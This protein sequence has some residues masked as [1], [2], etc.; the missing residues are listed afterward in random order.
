[1]SKKGFGILGAGMIAPL[2]ADALKK[3]DK[4][5]LVAICDLDESRSK[6]LAEK[7]A[8]DAK[9]Y[10]SLEDML[11]DKDVEVVNVVTPNHL[12]T[13]AVLKI[14][15]SK[16]HV[17]C[18]KPPAMSLADTDKMI[19]ACDDAGVLF[20]IYVQCRTRKP[21]QLMKQAIDEGRF[22]KIY[23]ADATMKWFRSG[24]YYKM[25]A[26]RSN[27]K[28]GAGVTIQHAFHY[29]DLIQYLMG[30]ASKVDAKMCNLGHPEV[31]LEDTLDARIEFKNGAI[32]AVQASTALWPGNDPRIEVYGENGTAIMD[33]AHFSKWEFKDAK[34]E[35][36]EVRN[37][38]NSDQKTAGSDPTALDSIDHQIV[39]DNC[40][41]VMD[42]N[43]KLII[44]CTD[45][46]PTLEMALGMY[47]SD[48]V[49]KLVELPL[50]NENEIWD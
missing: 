32:G 49:H 46:R 50:K 8:P 43:G 38:G 21:V 1:M 7:F 9:I 18:E 24:D 26:W 12:H 22:G 39:I 47:M 17:M 15:A 35:D 40:C 28:S 29:I 27:R 16:K 11:A 5:E 48:K 20:G 44:P 45:V 37:A 25:D 33:G 6:A 10:T 2:H 14:A 31:H 4:A 30:P 34:P 3:S 41:D 42:G 36:E 13:D 19:K 23:R